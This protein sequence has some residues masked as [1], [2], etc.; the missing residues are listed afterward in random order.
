MITDVCFP[1]NFHLFVHIT[2]K[3]GLLKKVVISC[4]LLLLLL[5]AFVRY[6]IYD[7]L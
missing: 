1:D 2:K 4:I 3:Q 6:V 5:H 7:D